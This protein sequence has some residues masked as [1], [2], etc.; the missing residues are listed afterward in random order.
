MLA[1]ST[2]YTQFCITHLGEKRSIVFSWR[3]APSFILELLSHHRAGSIVFNGN[4]VVYDQQQRLDHHEGDQ[5][6]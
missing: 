4:D 1:F 5:T 3:R 2:H 6:S